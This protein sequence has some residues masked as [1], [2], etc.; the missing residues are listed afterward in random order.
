MS[1]Q[2]AAW[3]EAACRLLVSLALLGCTGKKEDSVQP[4]EAQTV[5]VERVDQFVKDATAQLPTGTTLKNN[6]RSNE[7]A[8]DDPHRQRTRRQDLRRTPLHRRLTRQQRRLEIRPGH[9]ATGRLLGETGLPSQERQPHQTRPPIHRRKPR[10]LLRHHPRRLP[11]V[12][13]R[14]QLHHGQLRPGQVLRLHPDRRLTLH[15]AERHT[16][17]A[18][19]QSRKVPVEPVS[20]PIGR[21]RPCGTS[22]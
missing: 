6:Y 4:T 11:A 16:K 21:W 2:T 7:G 3:S 8:C 14:P 10:R 18:I 12:L 13:D 20:P 17:P 5:A 22:R 1:I 19:G 15:L 9:P